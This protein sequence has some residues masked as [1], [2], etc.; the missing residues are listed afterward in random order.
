MHT[1]GAVSERNVPLLLRRR[2]VQLDFGLR[3]GRFR[4]C[5]HRTGGTEPTSGLK[6]LAHLT[7]TMSEDGA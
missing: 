3:A 7:H 5:A 6:C 4:R 1:E 2:E